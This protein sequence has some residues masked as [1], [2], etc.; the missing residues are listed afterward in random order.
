MSD[1]THPC[2]RSC[3]RNVARSKAFCRECWADVPWR[4]QQAIY[5]SWGRV[6][7][8]QGDDPWGAHAELLLDAE[9]ALEGERDW[10]SVAA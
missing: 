9:A 2:R 4:V 10:D 1:R 5:A 3:S 7:K 8:D 6:L